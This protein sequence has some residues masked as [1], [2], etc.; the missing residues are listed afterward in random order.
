[1]TTLIRRVGKGYC[2]A[3]DGFYCYDLDLARVLQ[4]VAEFTRRLDPESPDGLGPSEAD[5]SEPAGRKAAE[6]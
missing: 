5:A 6:T 3:G 2:A 4:R 1:M